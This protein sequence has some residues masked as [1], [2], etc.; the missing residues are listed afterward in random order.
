MILSVVLSSSRMEFLPSSRQVFMM[1][2][3]P[4][5]VSKKRAGSPH[6]RSWT[7]MGRFWWLLSIIMSSTTSSLSSLLPYSLVWSQLI[8]NHA[9]IIFKNLHQVSKKKRKRWR[10]VRIRIKSYQN[11]GIIYIYFVCSS[12][13]LD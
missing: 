9:L 13:L 4:S 1:S 3:W 10:S 8:P 11:D 5:I 2:Y 6:L 12:W 7:K